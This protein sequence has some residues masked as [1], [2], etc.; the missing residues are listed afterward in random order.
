MFLRREGLFFD[1]DELSCR[2]SAR[3][4]LI[5]LRNREKNCKLRGKFSWTEGTAED[6]REEGFTAS[7]YR[8]FRNLKNVRAGNH[9]LASF[10]PPLWGSGILTGRFPRIS[11]GAIFMSSLWEEGE[12]L[13][14]G[15]IVRLVPT[16]CLSS[17]HCV[18][19]PYTVRLVPILWVWYLFEDRISGALLK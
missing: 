17:L 12:L 10:G 11:S 2:G 8:L 3:S 9:S 16:L 7:Q 5:V 15:E 4:F 18:S 13:G 14:T 6:E 1:P 19:R